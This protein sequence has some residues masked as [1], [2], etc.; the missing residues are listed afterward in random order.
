MDWDIW[1]PPKDEGNLKLI[2]D[3]LGDELDVR[4][5]PLGPSGENFIQTYQTRWGIIDFHLGV[6]G[7]TSFDEC[8]ARAIMHPNETGT[9]ARC[10]SDADLMTAKQ[11]A[12]R[13]KDQEDIRFLKYKSGEA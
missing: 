8:E 9:M 1:I 12:N 10:L 13:P 6:T 7:L 11:A 2:T 4:L 5:L 3:L